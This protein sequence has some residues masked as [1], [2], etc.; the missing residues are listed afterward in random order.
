[1]KD[2]DHDWGGWVERKLPNG[3]REGSVVCK[4]CD[5]VAIDHDC[6]VGP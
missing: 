1:V 2:C 4:V 6:A 3:A 5:V